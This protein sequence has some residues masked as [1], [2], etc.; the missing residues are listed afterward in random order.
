MEC[1]LAAGEVCE[2]ENAIQNLR[3]S[4]VA[5]KQMQ[6]PVSIMWTKT[7]LE[8]TELITRHSAEVF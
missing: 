5:N 3:H 7:N 8:K 4:D 1:G 2:A 6:F